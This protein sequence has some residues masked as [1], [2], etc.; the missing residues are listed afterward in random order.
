MFRPVASLCLVIAALALPVGA[1][2][3]L[4]DPMLWQMHDLVPHVELDYGQSIN[5]RAARGTPDFRVTPGLAFLSPRFVIISAIQAT[6]RRRSGQGAITFHSEE[7]LA[8]AIA[9][10]ACFANS[11]AKR[12]GP[13]WKTA[14]R[15]TPLT[16]ARMR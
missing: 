2:A 15:S 14:T 4:D 12:F 8:S 16:P 9:A 6:T 3:D 10:L 1:T 5:S 13:G 7:H 11:I